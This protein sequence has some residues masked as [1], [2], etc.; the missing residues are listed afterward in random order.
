MLVLIDNF[1]SFTYNLYQLLSAAG[2]H[3][4]VLRYDQASI[5]AIA[6]LQP[7]RIVISPGPKSPADVPQN[8]AIVRHFAGKVPILGVCLGHQVIGEVFGARVMRTAP[9]HGKVSTIAH[10]GLGIFAGVPQHVK[11]ARYHSLV[12]TDVPP[13]L[14]ITS[15]WDGIVMGLRHRDIAGLEGIQFHPESFMTEHGRTMID[16]FLQTRT[17]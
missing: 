2:A 11:V 6:D 14:T 3:V 1:D 8:G 5:G 17:T 15:V 12:V 9:Y 16:N 10:D 7:D 4:R 13:Q